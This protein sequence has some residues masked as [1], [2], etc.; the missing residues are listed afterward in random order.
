MGVA[1][2]SIV[3]VPMHLAHEGVDVLVRRAPQTVYKPV[4][5][6]RVALLEAQ[7]CHP[8]VVSSSAPKDMVAHDQ[9]GLSCPLT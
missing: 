7:K 2:F 1:L 4:W 6:T 5:A 9:D 8:A 3:G